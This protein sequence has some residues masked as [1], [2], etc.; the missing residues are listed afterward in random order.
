M[1]GQMSLEMVI[2]LLILLV[3]AAVVINLFLGNIKGISTVKDYQSDLDYRKFKTNCEG[4]CKEGSEG[5]LVAY[6]SEKLKSKDL[7]KNGIVDLLQ[8]A[9]GVWKMCE[10]GIY[11]FLI[12]PCE[13]ESGDIGAKECRQILCKAWVDALDSPSKATCKI[14]E[15]IPSVG[16]C[17]IT[18]IYENWYTQAGFKDQQTGV[19]DACGSPCK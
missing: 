16:T 6:C 19:K 10:D 12:A 4:Y 2:G 17:K 9:S 18:D 5:A 11:C 8:T 3:V 15:L 13:R 14:N 1:K 7:N